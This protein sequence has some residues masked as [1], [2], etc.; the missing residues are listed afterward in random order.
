MAK[1][2]ENIHI[3][4]ILRIV[5]D[6]SLGSVKLYKRKGSPQGVKVDE[7]ISNLMWKKLGNRKGWQ[8]ATMNAAANMFAKCFLAH[9]SFKEAAWFGPG[10]S[11]SYGWHIARSHLH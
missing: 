11:V 10:Q 6:T 5:D 2:C 7:C 8:V 4:E 3:G 9:Q 1:E